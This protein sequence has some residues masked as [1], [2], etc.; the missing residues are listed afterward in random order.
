MADIVNSLFGLTPREAE[1]QAT[2]QNY[3]LGA[4]I[5]AASIDPYDTAINQAAE[6][7]RQ[8]ALAALGG[9]A[10]RGV[11][12]LFGVQDER[13]KRATSIESIL[14][15]TQQELG[16]FVNNPAVLYPTL[17]KKLAD[18][19]FGREAMQ[20]GQ[21]GQKAIQDARLNQATIAEKEASAI[22]KNREK[23]GAFAQTLLS[24][25][26]KPGS[27]EWNK[28]MKDKIE[29]ETYIAEKT[30]TPENEAEAAILEQYKKESPDDPALA[31]KK[32][33][34]YKSLLRQK[35]HAAG[36]APGETKSI[37]I[38]RLDDS[39]KS[40]V[41]PKKEKLSVINEGLRLAQLAKTNP[42]AA[43]G[44]TSY[45]A[46][47]YDNGKLSNQDINLAGN[48]GSLP[49]KLINSFNKLLTGTPTE[50]N[51]ADAVE[52]LKLMQEGAA[53]GLNKEVDSFEKRWGTAPGV[54]KDT[55]KT[56]T[57]GSRFKLKSKNKPKTADEYLK[58]L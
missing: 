37:D 27:K 13:L 24:A 39:W 34:E 47:S 45:I 35:E 17:Q 53:T 9:Q 15:S 1:Q 30:V 48:P 41:E 20:V 51:I 16:D 56:Y 46:R 3:E 14:Q 55:I 29:K 38:G 10:V 5:G 54:S 12:G 19:G 4:L 42:A 32:F 40:F 43:V 22:A 11:A 44:L 2:Q 18:A 33:L 7:K 21:V 31:S 52:L 58:G 50:E 25:G 6:I 23:L 26:L 57:E 49:A 8:A 36:V 28:A